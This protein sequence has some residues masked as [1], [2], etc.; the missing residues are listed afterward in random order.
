MSKLTTEDIKK[1]ARLSALQVDD[2]E[3]QALQ[4]EIETI[5]GYVEQL[6]NVSIEG[7]EPTYQVTGLKNVVRQDDVIDY[8]VSQDELFKN[9]PARQDDQIKVKRVLG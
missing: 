3:A 7:Y 1:L 5:I 6:G 2:D 9:A 8:K 4:A